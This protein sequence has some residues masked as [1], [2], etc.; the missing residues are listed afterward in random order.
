MKALVKSERKPLRASGCRTS[1]CPRSGRTTCC[2]RVRK[3]AICG[4]DVHIYNWDDWAQRTIPVP[5]TVGHEFAGV[6]EQVGSH[7]NGF[8]VGDRV[9]GEGHITCGHCRNCRAGQAA[10]LPQ[11]RGRRRQSPRCVRRVS[12]DPRR[13][14]LQASRRHPRRDRRLLDPLGNAAHTALSFDLVG[15]DVLIT[16]AGP[17]GSWRLRS[18]AT[19]ARVTSSSPTSTT[20]GS[21]LAEKMGA[22]R[23]INVKSVDVRDVMKDLG[24]TEGF[25][26]GL[27]MSGAGSALRDHD[28]RDDEPRG[29]RRA[30]SGS[31][32][33]AS[34]STGIRS[35]SRG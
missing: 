2:I 12:G 5:M 3:T 29:S 19:S 10:P 21:E 34:P 32:P 7:V 24:M 35:S 6:V 31:L 9:S 26:V 17:I 27:E 23:A 14:R 28:V 15:E 13:Q 11:H 1:R 8:E 25:D 33:R 18:V 20:T 4:T 22:D 30:C 16:G